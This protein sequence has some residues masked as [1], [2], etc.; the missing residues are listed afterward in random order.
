MKT[1]NVFQD[2][3]YV[4]ILL[5]IERRIAKADEEARAEGIV[6]TDSSVRSTLNKVRKHAM[7][8]KGMAPVAGSPRDGLLAALYESLVELRS[9]LAVTSTGEETED[10]P[11]NDWV[12]A[13]RSIE[14]S[15]RTRGTG[16]GCRD[17]LE[18]IGPFVR[19]LQ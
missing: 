14:E 13:L 3:F 10:L 15:I 2:P 17:Y 11:L 9:A 12:L 18:F 16:P 7:E 8:G 6:L 1:T 4:P 5:Q 19:S